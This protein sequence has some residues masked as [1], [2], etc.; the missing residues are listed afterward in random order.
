ML[1]RNIKHERRCRILKKHDC[2]LAKVR[3]FACNKELQP[4]EPMHTWGSSMKDMCCEV[5]TACK[6]VLPFRHC[7]G[8]HKISGKGRMQRSC[9]QLDLRNN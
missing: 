5:D 1:N 9:A 3:A 2:R 7:F 4:G 8:F 6:Y